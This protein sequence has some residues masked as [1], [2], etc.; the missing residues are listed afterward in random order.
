MEFRSLP[1][2]FIADS[3]GLDFLNS[4]A[5][6]AEEPVD[7]IANGAGLL[8]WLEQAGMAPPD[9]LAALRAR[10]TAAD[11]DAVAEQARAL[12][13]GFRA[14]VDAR[15]GRPLGAADL[16][17]LA[18]L[19]ALLARDECYGEIVAVTEQQEGAL[20]YRESRRWNTP[21]SLLMPIAQALATLVSHEDFTHVKGVRGTPL[22]AA[23]RRSHARSRAPLVQHGELRQSGEGGRASPACEG[24]RRARIVKRAGSAFCGVVGAFSNGRPAMSDSDQKDNAKADDKANDPANTEADEAQTEMPEEI[25]HPQPP[26]HSD[27]QR[28]AMPERDDK[29]RKQA[30]SDRPGKQPGEGETPVG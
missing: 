6:P 17:E 3:P 22:H 11:F 28:S 13:E 4:I 26:K 18:P 25:K 16:P 9:A 1:A 23:I 24:A 29:D 5:T 21:E 10:F 14:F 7:W 19:N 30:P 12:R 27:D 20:V 15:K 8:A 2:I